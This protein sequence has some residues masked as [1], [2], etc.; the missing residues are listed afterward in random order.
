[1]ERLPPDVLRV[2]AGK[3]PPDDFLRM[4]RTNKQFYR[5]IC[6]SED[7]WRDQAREKLTSD[8]YVAQ[9]AAL[10]DIK[11]ALLT[12]GT[13]NINFFAEKG[14]D[15]AFFSLADKQSYKNDPD[16]IRCSVARA[17]SGSHQDLADKIY[18][19]Y[20]SGVYLD[21]IGSKMISAGLTGD[22]QKVLYH[23]PSANLQMIEDTLEAAA[24]KCHL[25]VLERLIQYPVPPN[26][27]KLMERAIDGNCPAV[28][29]FLLDAAQDRIRSVEPAIFFSSLVYAGI[30]G[31]W[32]IVNIFL[33]SDAVTEYLISSAL[34]FIDF[35]SNQYNVNERWNAI[36]LAKLLV[37]KMHSMK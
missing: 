20:G 31:R 1:M 32:D 15:K 16:F 2:I 14:F 10:Q 30:R 19:R 25:N 27:I 6:A 26:Y 8:S 33:E 17:L 23:L 3:M 24:E 9:T 28:V 18:D 34:S 12:P 22:L 37:K 36:D 21:I 5:T 11:R 13:G 29:R 4:C 7:F 35:M